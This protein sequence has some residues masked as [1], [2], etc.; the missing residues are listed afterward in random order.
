MCSIP[1][2]DNIDIKRMRVD[3]M[4]EKREVKFAEEFKC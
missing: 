3:T 4:T 2:A 1:E